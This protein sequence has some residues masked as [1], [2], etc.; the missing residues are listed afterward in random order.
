MSAQASQKLSG[1]HPPSPVAGRRRA[2]LVANGVKAAA[3][4]PLSRRDV[5]ALQVD[6]SPAARGALAAKFGRQYDQLV[7]GRTRAL[8]EAVLQ[9][10][11]KDVEPMVRQALAEAVAASPNLPH[12]V[13]VRLARDEL[14]VARPLLERSRVLSDDDLAAIARHHGLPHALVIAG[15]GHSSE[16]LCDLLVA[17]KEPEV[18]AA[19][20]GNSGAKLSTAT[21]RRIDE[22]YSKDRSLQECLIQR[23]DLPYE[24]VAQLLLAIGGRLEWP[25]LRERRMSKAEARELMAAVRERAT[26][27]IEAGD[28]GEPALERELSHRATRGEL[29]PEDIL[30]FVRDRDIGRVE[31]GL[32]LFASVDLARAHKLLHAADRRGLAALCARANFGAP[33]YVA[34]RMVLELAEQEIEGTDPDTAYSPDTITFIQKQYDLIR[35]DRTQIAF[36]FAA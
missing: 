27:S 25:V 31:I 13:A 7:E 21:L 19:L 33:H 16:A 34:L 28:H 2:Q 12:G 3:E 23:P 26:A 20:L 5:Q 17:S 35:S 32:A 11:V 18:V 24:L 8:A 4:P 9:L 29:G 30:A 15:R 10:L 1:A 6:P 36:W 22:N 14:D